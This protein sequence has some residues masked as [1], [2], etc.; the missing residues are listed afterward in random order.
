MMFLRVVALT[1]AWSAV[2][3]RCGID[4]AIWP[5]VGPQGIIY[6]A[7]QGGAF[8]TGKAAVSPRR[9]DLDAVVQ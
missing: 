3:V 7:S 8:A 9:T 6:T 5:A 1:S 4:H 2:V